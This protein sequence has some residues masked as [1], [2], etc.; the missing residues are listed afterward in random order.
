MRKHEDMVVISVLTICF[1]SFVSSLLLKNLKRQYTI[2][3]M[4]LNC[5]LETIGS[6]YIFK[7][8]NCLLDATTNLHF[9]GGFF[10][11]LEFFF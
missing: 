7:I 3:A 10:A 6:T 11:F 4:Y 9:L 5:P 8:V 2:L 1:F